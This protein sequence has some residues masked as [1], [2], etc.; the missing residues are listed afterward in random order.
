M[1]GWSRSSELA[2]DYRAAGALLRRA[3]RQRAGCLG[4]KSLVTWST[5]CTP[6]PGD[7]TPVGRV[8]RSCRDEYDVSDRPLPWR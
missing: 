1:S 6:G 5:M 2:S 4:S 3:D 7:R 8:L